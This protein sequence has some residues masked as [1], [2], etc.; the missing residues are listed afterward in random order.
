MKQVFTILL[1]V[2][3]QQF[4]QRNTGFF[5]FLFVV[6]FGVVQNP[7]SYHLSLMQGIVSSYTTLTIAV[8]VWALYGCKCG[9]FFLKTL[10]A[11]EQLFLYQL[12]ALTLRQIFV[13]LNAVQALLLLPVLVY[14]I[15]T[16]GV[17]FYIHQPAAAVV[18][19]LSIAAIQGVSVLLYYHGISRPAKKI[20]FTLP[21]VFHYH[22]PKPFYSFLLYYNLYE[23][24]LKTVAVKFISF[25]LLFL[26]LVWNG[27]HFEFSDFIIFFGVSIA[28]HAVIVFDGIQ[29][30]EKDFKVL[31][32]MPLPLYKLF[33]LFLISYTLLLLPEAFILWYYSYRVALSVPVAS[34]FI[35]YIAM[36]LFFTALSYEK[37]IKIETYLLYVG[38]I[39]VLS[40]LIAPLKSFAAEGSCVAAIAFITF[41]GLYYKYEPY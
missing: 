5:L 19:L 33:L 31:R 7:L 22:L 9:V 36:L 12:Q 39:T 3:V 32:N 24:K 11:K 18:I 2:L 17:G 21:I 8:V 6:L 37:G 13:L 40:L 28:A 26:P 35:Y 41:A 16:A 27:D 23:G 15:I 14:G 10:A 29:F 4:Y 30:L 34:L 25:V 1:K 38:L 20:G